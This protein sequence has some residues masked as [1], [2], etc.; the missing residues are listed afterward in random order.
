M[1]WEEWSKPRKLEY[2][3]SQLDSLTIVLLIIIVNLVFWVIC[4]CAKLE[5]RTMKKY[6]NKRTKAK[7]AVVLG[8][9]GHTAEMLKLIANL[10]RDVFTPRIYYVAKTDDFSVTKLKDF[11]KERTDYRIKRIPRARE[12]GQSY[13]SSIFSFIGATI[14]CFGHALDDM[15]DVL[16]VNGPGTCL[17]VF[18]C[19]YITHGWVQLIY[20][21]SICRVQ[22][23]SLTCRILKRFSSVTLV[24]W[25]ELA[26]NYKGTT[27]IGRML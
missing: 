15:V 22:T 7:I 17:P 13:L 6:M 14:E 9:G 23:L 27:Y 26:E 21:E 10:D 5:A 20:V 19:H 3:T 16:L 2:Y 8:S 11:E 1:N 4:K 12:V 24:Q 25:P 18:F